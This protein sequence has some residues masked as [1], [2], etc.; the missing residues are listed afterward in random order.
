M[1][2][3]ILTLVFSSLLLFGGTVYAESENSLIIESQSIPLTADNYAT[4]KLGMY[5]SATLGIE[6]EK[7]NITDYQLGTPFKMINEE[8]EEEGTALYPVMYQDTIRFVFYVRKTD[9]EYS[10]TLSKFLADELQ[11]IKDQSISTIENPITFHEKN[12]DIFYESNGTI[13][14]IYTSPIRPE[15]EEAVTDTVLIDSKKEISNLETINTLEEIE[16][17]V[18]NTDSNKPLGRSTLIDKANNRINWSVTETQGSSSWCSA[19]AAAMILNNKNDKRPTSVAQIVSW[20]KKPSDKGF[21]DDEIIKYANTRGVYPYKVNR[22]MNWNE[23]V[24]EVRKSNAIWG[25]WRGT[26]NYKGAYHA[27]DVIGTYYENTFGEFKGY[28]VWNP[29][30]KSIDL[31]E[32]KSSV[33]YSVPNGSFIWERSVTNW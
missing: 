17:T 11:F 22:I 9:G 12:K 19:Y 10:G 3:I 27:I 18:N 8:N 5:L 28:W 7:T 6:N 14:K 32:A 24:T 30:Y 26:G 1:K 2:K 23:V 33:V 16:F 15:N 4:E 29:W 21:S 20:G 31:V 25:A 13:H